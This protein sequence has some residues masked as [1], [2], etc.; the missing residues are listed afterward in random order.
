MLN[1]S[2]GKADIKDDHIERIRRAHQNDLENTSS[3]AAQVVLASDVPQDCIEP[4]VSLT[5]TN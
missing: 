3:A 1:P 4:N 2:K 5:G